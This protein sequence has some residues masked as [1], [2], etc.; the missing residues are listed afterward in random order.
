MEFSCDSLREQEGNIEEL[1]L[2]KRAVRK[3]HDTIRLAIPHNNIV[4]LN[5]FIISEQ[6]AADCQNHRA[7][8]FALNE[9]FSRYNRKC[10]MPKVLHLNY[11]FLKSIVKN[12]YSPRNLRP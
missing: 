4:A 2:I 7:T 11:F 8:Q 6:T 3:M 12:I 5:E 1:T 9:N 10:R